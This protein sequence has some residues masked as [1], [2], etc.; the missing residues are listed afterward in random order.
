MVLFKSAAECGIFL[1]IVVEVLA[2]LK[3]FDDRVVVVVF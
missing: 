2:Y 3:Y 1:Y